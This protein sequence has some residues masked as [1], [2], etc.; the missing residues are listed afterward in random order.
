MLSVAS[1]TA[2]SRR[3]LPVAANAVAARTFASSAPAEATLR[4]LE[5]RVK[6]VKNIQKVRL[7]SSGILMCA[8]ALLLAVDADCCCPPR[9][10]VMDPVGLA[11]RCCSCASCCTRRSQQITSS[12]KMIATTKLNKAQAGAAVRGSSLLGLALRFCADS[13]GCVCSSRQQP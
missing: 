5:R 11:C 7:H 8:Y 10:S 3:A 2:L 13:P 1:R 6:S 4:D 9:C 12:M